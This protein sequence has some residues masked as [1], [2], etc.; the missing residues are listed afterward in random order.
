MVIVNV[1]S[2]APV[3]TAVTAVAAAAAVVRVTWD[4]KC[5]FLYCLCVVKGD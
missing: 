2:V 5:I 1:V 4:L 3:I